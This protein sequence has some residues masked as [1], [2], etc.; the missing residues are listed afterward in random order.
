MAAVGLHHGRAHRRGGARRNYLTDDERSEYRLR[1]AQLAALESDIERARDTARQAAAGVRL[2]VASHPEASSAAVHGERSR[3]TDGA[4]IIIRPIERAD[5]HDLAA[6]LHRLGALS[7]LQLFRAPVERLSAEQLSQLTEVDHVS[8][9][10]V[11][12]FDAATGEGIG[13][14]QYIRSSEDPTQA[15]VTCAVLDRWQHR[16]VGAALAERL[17]RQARAA[18]IERLTAFSIVGNDAARRLMAHVACSIS[19]RSAGGI[20]EMTGIARH[21]TS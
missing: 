21:A 13:L 8:H 7:R 11:V 17:A 15:E 9:D 19:E 6:G 12:A 10:A 16:G 3:L 1:K 14:A 20:I 18:G 4:K 2:G 5:A